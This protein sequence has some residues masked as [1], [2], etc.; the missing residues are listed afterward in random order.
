LYFLQPG[1]VATGQ[2]CTNA[3]KVSTPVQPA[4]AMDVIGGNGKI[5]H[6]RAYSRRRPIKGATDSGFERP[7]PS[8]QQVS[9]QQRNSS[10]PHHVQVLPQASGQ[11]T[12][13]PKHSQW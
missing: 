1:H 3:D 2:H 8:P 6:R 4:A 12:V 11:G 13:G 9:G 5:S 7:G 10:E